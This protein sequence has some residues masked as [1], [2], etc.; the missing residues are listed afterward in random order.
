MWTI[1]LG[2]NGALFKPICPTDDDTVEGAL[3]GISIFSTTPH[4]F[5]GVWFTT[6]KRANKMSQ[7]E[8]AIEINDKN[9]ARWSQAAVAHN[10]LFLGSLENL[11]PLGSLQRAAWLALERSSEGVLIGQTM[12]SQAK[13]AGKEPVHSA[14][15]QRDGIISVY[16]PDTS[17]E[18]VREC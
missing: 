3:C 17:G 15:P 7:A 6:P 14:G 1:C 5:H 2:L 13:H 11:R 16:Y 4:V 12:A 9:G 18:K 10:A 8:K